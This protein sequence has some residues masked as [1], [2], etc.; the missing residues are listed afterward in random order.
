MKRKEV[1]KMERKK[2]YI[3]PCS[4]IG[5]VFGSI[6]REAAYIVVN[7]LRKDSTKLS[8]LPLIVKGKRDLIEDIRKNHVITI[9]GCPLKC[10]FNDVF[11]TVGT[12]DKS[13]LSTDAV[14]ENRDIK[15]EPD[16]FPIGK[17]AKQVA[18]KFAEKLAEEVDEILKNDKEAV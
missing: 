6:G 4:G 15:P 1:I 5:K 14:K 9:D 7:E 10:S 3:L 18:R 8:C 12:V 16:V 13:M 17:N 11:E 2:V